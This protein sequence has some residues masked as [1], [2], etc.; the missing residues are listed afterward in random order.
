MTVAGLE[1]ERN[2]SGWGKDQLHRLVAAFLEVRFPT[3]VALNKCDRPSAKDRVA[4][5]L[6]D[7]ATDDLVP[8]CARV[9]AALVVARA[10]G[11]LAYEDGAGAFEGGDGPAGAADYLTEWGTTGV[12]DAISRAVAGARPVHAYP[13][14]DLES[15]R[16]AL[17]P[18]PLATCL[19]FRRWATVEDVFIALKRRGGG[20]DFVRADALSADGSKRRQAKL[21]T[22]SAPTPRCS[23]CRRTGRPR[24]SSR[25]VLL[26]VS[27][28]TRLFFSRLQTSAAGACRFVHNSVP[29]K[30][31]RGWQPPRT[32][33]NVCPFNQRLFFVVKPFR[34]VFLETLSLAG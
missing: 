29:P 34:D 21:G 17:S 5:L 8:C 33:C 22:R 1:K 11:S 16:G 23:R 27:C 24:G 31:N 10:N 2:I 6:A 25:V 26:D 14:A 30:Q 9:E 28:L 18:G 4:E 13:V 19:A 15:L 20:G 12:L 32:M 3:V 7:G